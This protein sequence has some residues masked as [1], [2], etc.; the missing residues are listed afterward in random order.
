MM[1][2]ESNPEVKIVNEIKSNIAQS[3]GRKSH[4]AKYFSRIVFSVFY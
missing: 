4:F 1:T 3:T 2:L